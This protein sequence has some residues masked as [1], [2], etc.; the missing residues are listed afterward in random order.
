MERIDVTIVCTKIRTEKLVSAQIQFISPDDLEC[1]EIVTLENMTSFSVSAR[2][3]MFKAPNQARNNHQ[4]L[5]NKA[6]SQNS[7]RSRSRKKQNQT[8]KQNKPN[9]NKKE[10]TQ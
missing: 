9:P 2:F 10:Q 1:D 7:Q 6:S 8:N 3:R 4:N 5:I